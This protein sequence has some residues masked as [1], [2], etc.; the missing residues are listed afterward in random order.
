[1]A[2]IPSFLLLFTD[3]QTHLVLSKWNN[4]FSIYCNFYVAEYRP[5]PDVIRKEYDRKLQII[6]FVH[7][8]SS[9]LSA[10][11]WLVHGRPGRV[12]LG[13]S[14]LQTFPKHIIRWLRTVDWAIEKLCS[15]PELSVYINGNLVDW[16]DQDAKGVKLFSTPLSHQAHYHIYPAGVSIN[17]VMNDLWWD[18]EPKSAFMDLVYF[19]GC[20]MTWIVIWTPI[21]RRCTCVGNKTYDISCAT[22]YR[23]AN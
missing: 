13:I 8:P 9:D 20:F 5:F 23:C 18:D 12:S 7:I 17:M 14:T 2:S 11:L 4:L 15:L 16:L 1:M 6:D 22:G 19:N 10:L 21:R 3:Q